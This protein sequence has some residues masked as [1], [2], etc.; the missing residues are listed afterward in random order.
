[1]DGQVTR[2]RPRLF[3]GWGLL[4]LPVGGFL[5]AVFVVPLG[6][7]LLRSV[8]DPEPGTGNYQDFF[9][10]SVYLDVL[11]N[12]FTT[13]GLVTLI[14]LLLGFPYAYLMTLA[15]PFWRTVLLIAVL[16]PF[17]T[18]LLVRTFAWVLILRDTGVVNDALGATGLIDEPVPLLRNLTGV[19]I[20]MVQ[21]M[22]PFAVLPLYATM[23]GI[24]RRLLRAAEGLGA[25]PAFA[26]WRI[27]APL[28]APGA[29]AAAL[30]VFVSAL[31]FYVTPA[32][33]GGPKNVM[34]GEFIVQQLSGVLR[35][36][37]ASALAVILLVVTAALLLVVARLTDLRRMIGGAR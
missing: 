11:V 6:G 14:T 9:G 19:L 7:V 21:V 10:S 30:L 22:L 26:F 20:G 37:F 3:D 23:R 34:L 25:R 31:G 27:Y 32:L 33:L 17:W 28:T 2:P 12:T 8:T 18:S 16:V 24:D 29:A 36:G 4:I 35:W 1:V 5:L 13:A 15:R